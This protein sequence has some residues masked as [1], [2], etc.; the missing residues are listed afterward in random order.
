M[1]KLDLSK[2]RDTI[3]RRT[4]DAISHA[5]DNDLIVADVPKVRVADS[6]FDT[7]VLKPNWTDALEKARLYFEK[8]EDYEMCQF[9][10]ILTK[11]TKKLKK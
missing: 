8:I 9:C 1:A 10:V 2:E 5:I 6:E 3:F 7:F 4:V 11:K